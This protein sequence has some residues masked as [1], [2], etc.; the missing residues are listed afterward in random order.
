M[1]TLFAAGV[2]AASLALTPMP[3]E[4]GPL[5]L[6][7][8]GA[9][10]QFVVH[11]DMEAMRESEAGRSLLGIITQVADDAFDDIEDELGIDPRSNIDDATIYGA[12]D[13]EGDLVIIVH[14][15]GELADALDRARKE[16]EDIDS[17][18]A[19][20]VEYEMWDAGDETLYV[21]EASRR[22]ETTVVIAFDED[23]LVDAVRVLAGE[24][25]GLRG[26]AADAFGE[27]LRNA[28]LFVSVAGDMGL[29]EFGQASDMLRLTDRVIVQVGGD[30]S[31][32]MSLDLTA[33]SHD[34]AKNLM[35]LLQGAVAV[36]R[37]AASQQDFGTREER[38]ALL[39]LADGMQFESDGRRV[40]I[41]ASFDPDW[42]AEMIEEHAD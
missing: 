35:G 9:D 10:A 20:G 15:N 2:C 32:D 25:D 38:D 21:F 5:N 11:I 6:R 13:D 42:L 41:S 24:D 33:D 26:D 40:R 36:A 37:I 23:R 16:I 34:D 31:L 1:R 18:R 22:G 8:V 19:R 28:F 39:A 7:H 12:S 17:D 3:A 29:D 27:P 30:E 14:G 4:A